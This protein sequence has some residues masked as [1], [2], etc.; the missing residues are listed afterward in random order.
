MEVKNVNIFRK[1]LKYKVNEKEGSGV[2]E[3]VVLF[4][5]AMLLLSVIFE[6]IRVQILANGIRDNFERAVLTVASENYDE[7][8]AGFREIL[9]MGGIYEGGPE[10]GGDID[11]EPEWVSINDHGNVEEELQELL[12]LELKE[13]TDTYANIKDNYYI[14]NIEVEILNYSHE[15]SGRYEIRGTIQL[16]LPMYFSGIKVMDISFPINIKTAY[17]PKY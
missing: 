6:Y 1:R 7:V 14:E 4:L 9:Y 8:Y 16:R 17:T 13:D 5:F 3:A 2:I 12:K 11:E 15:A 10:G